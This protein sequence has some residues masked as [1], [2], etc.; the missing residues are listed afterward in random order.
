MDLK[1]IKNSSE[2][3]EKIVLTYRECTVQSQK[4]ETNDMQLVTAERYSHE[5]NEWQPTSKDPL[6]DIEVAK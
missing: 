6:L 5:L 3:S 2:E 1:Y 4:L